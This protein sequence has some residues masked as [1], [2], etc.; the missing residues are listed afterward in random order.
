[1]YRR[2]SLQN[3]PSIGR[4]RHNQLSMLSLCFRRS[5]RLARQRQPRMPLCR[6]SRSAPNTVCR[7]PPKTLWRLRVCLT[8][9]AR[10]LWVNN[11]AAV[12]APAVERRARFSSAI[13]RLANSGVRQSADSPLTG[14]TRHQWATSS[15]IK[16]KP[17][18]PAAADYFLTRSKAIRWVASATAMPSA[19]PWPSLRYRRGFLPGLQREVP[20]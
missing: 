10:A 6:A 1:M 20:W 17:L 12:D 18:S 5:L 13:V 4:K 2:S 19:R 11:I 7:S 16:L 15:K 3:A 14:I 8:F 9:Q